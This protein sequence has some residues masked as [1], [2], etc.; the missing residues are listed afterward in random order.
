MTGL[1]VVYAVE[2]LGLGRDDARI[3]WLFAGA[4]VG[5]LL[6]ALA[7]PRL[8]RRFSPPSLALGG[9]GR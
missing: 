5:S 9:A 2:G 8:A 7:L 6:A 4:A 1:V 3:A